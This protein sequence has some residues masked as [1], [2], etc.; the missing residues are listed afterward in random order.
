MIFNE[1]M[2][3]SPAIIFRSLKKFQVLAVHC[4]ICKNKDVFVRNDK[5]FPKVQI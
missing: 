4:G 3:V 1:F 2:L 5:I